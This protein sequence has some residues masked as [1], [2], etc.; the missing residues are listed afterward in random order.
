VIVLGID[1]SVMPRFIE[2]LQ[3]TFTGDVESARL[4]L[5]R[6]VEADTSN[7]ASVQKEVERIEDMVESGTELL[8]LYWRNPQIFEFF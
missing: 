7:E 8:K 5:L 1:Y 4:H 6:E 2:F 3:R